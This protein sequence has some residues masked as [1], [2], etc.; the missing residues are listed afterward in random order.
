MSFRAKLLLMFSISVVIVVALVSAI[1]SATLRDSFER[2]DQERTAALITQFRNEFTRRGQ[3]V[4]QR[5]AAIAERDSTLRMA[6]DLGR[7]N[8]DPS[9]YVNE[10]SAV[11][12]AHQ[13]D[14]LEFVS[15]DGTIISSAQWPARFG[16]KEEF[17]AQPADWPAQPAFL[18]REEVADGAILALIAVRPVPAAGSQLL[19]VAGGERLDKSFLA[20]LVLPEGVRA[21][22]Y[23]STGL[24]F[25]PAALTDTSGPVPQADA[26]GPLIA[27]V[28]RAKRE[29][30]QMISWSNDAAGDEM[31]HA[32]PLSGRDGEV[33]GVFILGSSRREIVTVERHLGWVALLVACAGVLLGIVLSGWVAARVTQP[34][35]ELADA[36][37]Q[38]AR[39]NLD[40]RVYTS[41]KD[42]LGDLAAVFN[43]MTRD[44]SDHRDRLVQ[45]ERVAAWRELARRLAHELKNP[46]FPLQITVENL[47]RARERDPGQFDEVFQ[48]STRTLLAELANLK[49]IIGRFSDFARMPAPQ[50]QRADLNDIVRNALKVFEAR[51]A[52][53]NG[54]PAIRV[55]TALDAR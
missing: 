4:S 37:R 9:P 31:L 51:F 40:A 19:Y 14:L 6:A 36:A 45:A 22:F 30:S 3:E 10:A 5:V 12:A 23:R 41:A 48:E 39:G 53:G 7:P 20:T 52:G 32:I 55:E 44:L 11:A 13:L 2:L 8:A 54:S 50:V 28:L 38:I 42:E 49:A 15:P 43:R 18:R 25:S 26:L 21:M 1:V 35:D 33:L 34:V 47:V 46:L 27:E 24:R 29:S 17:L 16:Y